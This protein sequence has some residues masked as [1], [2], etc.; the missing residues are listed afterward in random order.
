MARH[1]L[2]LDLAPLSGSKKPDW[3][4]LAT[5]LFTNFLSPGLRNHIKYV[6]RTSHTNSLGWLE[7]SLEQQVAKVKGPFDFTFDPEKEYALSAAA[8]LHWTTLG[9]ASSFAKRPHFD[10]WFNAFG[11]DWRGPTF[12]L[13]ALLTTSPIPLVEVT[14]EKKKY[15]VGVV[16]GK[17]GSF[18]FD[19]DVGPQSRA[20]LSK[21]DFARLDAAAKSGRCECFLCQSLRPKFGKR[22]KEAKR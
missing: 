9:L 15:L 19:V 21:G 3:K 22:K 11:I 7:Y 20:Q 6:P 10:K 8:G 14:D 4:K 2:S 18:V 1:T 17:K 12:D 13:P 16:R 5:L